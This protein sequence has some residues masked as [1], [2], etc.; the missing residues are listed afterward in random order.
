[1][2]QKSR[3]SPN[4]LLIAGLGLAGGAICGAVGH[5]ALKLGTPETGGLA[6]LGLLIFAGAGLIPSF[7]GD[8]KRLAA[9]VAVKKN[10]DSAYEM[11]SLGRL[12]QAENLLKEAIERAQILGETDLNHLA[13]VHSLGNL[14]LLQKKLDL[15][16]K[17][18]RAAIK[19]Y[20]Q[21]GKTDDQNFAHCLRDCAFAAEGRNQL[22]ESLT[23]AR[24]AL[25]LSEKLGETRDVAEIMSLVARNTRASGHFQ[26]AVQ[27]YQRVK[28][29]Q[30]KQFGEHSPEVIA[31]VLT[32]ARCMRSLDQLGE[33]IDHYKDA[34]VRINKAERPSRTSEAEALL[35]MAEVSLAQASY[36][37]VEP[38]CLGSL[39][40][41]QTYVGPKEKLLVRLATATREAREQLNLA[42]SEH[43]FL[44][45]F[46]QN[47]DQVR[48]IFRE[49]TDLI[50]QKD[51]TGWGPVQWT[52][53][54]GWEDLMRWLMRNG[55]QSND[56]EDSV[57]SPVH[58]AA[59]YSKGSTIT[60]LHEQGVVLDVVGPQGWN[61]VHFASYHGRQDCVEQLLARGCQADLLE[62]LGR[63][64]LHLAADRGHNDLVALLLGKGLGKDIQDLKYGRTAL[65][66]AARAGH[67]AVV[68]TLMMNGASES[69]ADKGG[70][71]PIDLAQEAGH[72]GLTVAMKHF[73]S[74]MEN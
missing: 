11:Q 57:M 23:L 26:E 52:L 42:F 21:L 72:R 24:R 8:T 49:N 54:L 35:E 60:F 71:T 53:F 2:A 18:Y 68:R 29:I 15:A 69:L 20:E 61:A 5:F 34:L 40:V 55:G 63:S 7:G 50:Q 43:D 13:A 56:F 64:A 45:L 16:D 47:R 14:Y 66:Y 48:D 17:Q 6:A 38:L 58:V 1:M 22:E 3:K 25:A 30:L 19:V 37:N 62:K 65:H 36:K 27:T 31:T 67:G 59:A 74:A 39:K 73:R 70:K 41:L 9:Q 4:Y 28:D 32:T 10:V 46:T 12:D 51:R 33:A 44:W